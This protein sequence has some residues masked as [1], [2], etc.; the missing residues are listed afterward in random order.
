MCVVCGASGSQ[1]VHVG[2]VEA[3]TRRAQTKTARL[4]VFVE[5]GGGDHRVELRFGELLAEPLHRMPQL[6]ARDAPVV[7]RVERLRTEALRSST[8]MLVQDE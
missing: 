2:G 7:V 5:V 3:A 4:A 1:E 8:P 6:L